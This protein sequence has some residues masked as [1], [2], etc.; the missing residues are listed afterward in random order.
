M[1][2]SSIE[3]LVI[4][5]YLVFLFGI[6][7][8]FSKINFGDDDYFCSG[9]R[10]SWWLVGMSVFMS[11]ISVA[12]FPSDVGLALPGFVRLI[13]LVPNTLK[14]RL[15]VLFVAGFIASVGL[16]L[17]LAGG[18]HARMVA[19]DLA[20]DADGQAFGCEPSRREKV[21]R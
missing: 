14:D 17:N 20:A 5:V 15:G 11:G 4:L 12:T 19:L 7:I 16:L 3:I 6:G 18:R 2:A 21:G 1:Q 10:D 13:L 9:G 8:I